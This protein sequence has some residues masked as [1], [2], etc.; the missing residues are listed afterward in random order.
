LLICYLVDSFWPWTRVPN[1]QHKHA[2]IFPV[3]D[4]SEWIWDRHGLAR[5]Y[6]HS[7]LDNQF[8]RADDVIVGFR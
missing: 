4:V 6:N 1:Y 8:V 5:L 3:S 2:A 7:L